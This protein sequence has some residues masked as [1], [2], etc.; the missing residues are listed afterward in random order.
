MLNRTQ[1]HLAVGRADVV[2]HNSFYMSAPYF[3]TGELDPRWWKD[4]RTLAAV[5][6]PL[7]LGEHAFV[8]VEGDVLADVTA[9]PH[10]AV[11]VYGDLRSSIRTA[12]HNEIVIAGDVREGASIADVRF[13]HV[14]V[15]GDLAGCLRSRGSCKAW[16]QGH[17]RGQVWTGYPTT[18][19]HVLGDCTATIQPVEKASL[20]HL[21]IGGHMP[22]ASLEAT[23]AFGYTEF[24]ASVGRSDRPAGLYPD[25]TFHEALRQRRGDIRW[26]IG[27][28][29]GQSVSEADELR[30]LSGSHRRSQTT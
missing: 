30:R 23:A 2:A 27:G 22:Y 16:V 10:S 25:K 14:F 17:L 20:L 28:L 26:A 3:H 12:E 4:V 13:L 1:L 9:A 7:T 24:L 11:V 6:A 15:G 18:R 19:L 5:T 29:A 8:I 21:D